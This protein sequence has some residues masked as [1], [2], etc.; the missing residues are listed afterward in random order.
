MLVQPLWCNVGCFMLVAFMYANLVVS[1]TQVDRTEYS[2]L[3]QMVKQ[4]Q[5][6][7]YWEYIKLCLVI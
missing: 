6:L 2:S 3:A 1:M 7:W 4:V 5:S